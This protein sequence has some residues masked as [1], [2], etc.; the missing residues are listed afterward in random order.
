MRICKAL[1]V[2][3]PAL[4]T[5]TSTNASLSQ[6]CTDINTVPTQG[7][8]VKTFTDK[9]EHL[10]NIRNTLVEAANEFEEHL[11]EAV[12]LRLSCI[13]RELYDLTKLTAIK[14]TAKDSEGSTKTSSISEDL[15]TQLETQQQF[16][17][18]FMDITTNINLDAQS[19]KMKILKNQEMMV[20]KILEDNKE[21]LHFVCQEHME[22]MKNVSSLSDAI[23]Y[24]SELMLSLEKTLSDEVSWVEQ[25]YKELLEQYNYE[26]TLH[27]QSRSLTLEE[28]KNRLIVLLRGTATQTELDDLKSHQKCELMKLQEE[29]GAEVQR[30]ERQLAV[31]DQETLMALDDEVEQLRAQIDHD[32]NVR[33]CISNSLCSELENIKIQVTQLEDANDEL[34]KIIDPATDVNSVLFQR[35]L[36]S[37]YSD[38]DWY[39]K[40]V[41]L[42]SHVTLQLLHYYSVAESY[43]NKPQDHKVI[44]EIIEDQSAMHQPELF[45]GRVLDLSFLS[46][47]MP[48]D[49]YTSQLNMFAEDTAL[50]TGLISKTIYTDQGDEPELVS[51]SGSVLDSTAMS[52][53]M[54]DDVD[55]DEQVRSIL[56]KSYPQLMSILKGRWDRVVV[57]NL[58]KEVQEL[59]ISLQA[60]AGMLKIFLHS[61]SSENQ[62]LSSHTIREVTQ[63]DSVKETVS[64]LSQH[65]LS[66]TIEALSKTPGDEV[67]PNKSIRESESSCSTVSLKIHNVRKKFMKN[68]KDTEVDLPLKEDALDVTS[69][70]SQ[71]E[72]FKELTQLDLVNLSESLTIL[73][74]QDESFINFTKLKHQELIDEEKLKEVL[75][76]LCQNVQFTACLQMKLHHVEGLLKGLEEEKKT[77]ED[78]NCRLNHYSKNLA[79]ELQVVKDQIEELEAVQQDQEGGTACTQY[80]AKMEASKDIKERVR[81]TLSAKNK[82]LMDHTELVARVGD[83]EGI[84]ETLVRENDATVEALKSR[85]SDLSQQLEVAD[86]QLR[87][88]RQ[89]LEEHASERDQEM[90]DLMHTKDKL[91]SQLREK[92]ALLVQHANLEK[93]I[94]DLREI[95]Q[96]LEAQVDGKCVEESNLNTQVETLTAALS[97]AHQDSQDLTSKL[98]ALQCGGSIQGGGHSR[99]QLPT[100]GPRTV[101]PEEEENDA[102]LTGTSLFMELRDEYRQG[103]RNVSGQTLLQ[104]IEETVERTTSGLEALQLS[105]SS[106]SQ[107]AEDLSIQDHLDVPSLQER[108][109][110]RALSPASVDRRLEDKLLTLERTTEA[111]VKRTRDLE[112]TLKNLRVDHEEVTAERDVLQEH[113]KEQ[114]VQISSL[115]A[116]LD[117]IRRSEHPM[118]A[119]LRQRLNFVQENLEKKR[120]EITK[121][122][123]EIEELKHNLTSTRGKLMSRE[124]ELERMQCVSQPHSLPLSTADQLLTKQRHLEDELATKYIIIEKLKKELVDA[125]KSDTI[126]PLLAQSLIE[127]KNA[128][129]SE[130]YQQLRNMKSR[131]HEVVTF[132]ANGTSLAECKNMLQK[133][134]GDDKFSPR[135]SD[136]EAPEVLRKTLVQD[137]DLT[138]Y[139]S[140]TSHV[141]SSLK[142]GPCPFIISN[143]KSEDGVS[144]ITQPS[145]GNL[146][147]MSLQHEAPHEISKTSSSHT[148]M[149]FKI[150]PLHKDDRLETS[151]PSVGGAG[152][153][154]DEEIKE[155]VEE[156]KA[157]PHT[158]PFEEG[159]PFT[160]EEYESLCSASGEVTVLR[161]QI[162]LM[163]KEIDNLNKYQ[164]KL[165]EDYKVAQEMLEAREEE[166]TQLSEEIE[167]TGSLPLPSQTLHMQDMC[168]RLEEQV[169]ELQERFN[170]AAAMNREYEEEIEKLNLRTSQYEQEIKELQ[171]GIELLRKEDKQKEVLLLEKETSLQETRRE[172]DKN[173][174][175][176]KQKQMELCREMKVLHEQMEQLKQQHEEQSAALQRKTEE[177]AQLSAQLDLVHSEMKE[178]LSHTNKEMA[179]LEE[180]YQQEISDM[181]E[182]QILREKQLCSD[183]EERMAAQVS[184]LSVK[185][186]RDKEEAVARQQRFYKSALHE[187]NREKERVQMELQ[188]QRR[189]VDFHN[190]SQQ[191]SHLFDSVDALNAGVKLELDKSGQLDNSLV[192]FVKHGHTRGDPG[193]L[194]TRAS[195][196]VSDISDGDGPSDIAVKVQRLMN[197]V[198]K[199][200]IEMLTLIELMFLQKH[201]THLDNSQRTLISQSGFIATGSTESSIADIQERS[202]QSV[203]G[204]TEDGV[205]VG[206][207]T[208]LLRH[209][210]ALE[211]EL[212][213]KD[214]EI[215]RKV[216]LLEFRLEQEKKLGIE[217]KLSFESEKKR[218]RELIE[219]LRE[220]KL[221][222]ADR[223]S[224]LKILRSQFFVQRL[225]LQKIQGESS[226]VNETLETNEKEVEMLKDAL[227][228]ERNNFSRVSKALNQQRHL[229]AVTRSQQDGVIKDLRCTLDSERERIMDLY[230]QLA[231]LTN[232]Q[233][234]K[235]CDR[236]GIITRRMESERITSG[237]KETTTAITPTVEDLQMQLAV[238]KE[239]FTELQR[240]YERERRK[241]VTQNEQAH[242]ERAC[243]KVE[244]MEEQ[245]KCAE[246]TKTIRNM[247]MEKDTLLRQMSQNRERLQHQESRIREMEAEIRKLEGDLRAQADGHQA[248]SH[249]VREEDAQLHINYTR[250]LNKL[251]EAEA[252]LCTLR[253]KLRTVTKD[254]ELS[255]EKEEQLQQ[256]LTTEKMAINRLGLP[257]LARINNLDEYFELQL[258][259]NLELCK[260]V[261]RLT[262]DRQAMRQKIDTLENTVTDLTEQLIKTKAAAS[263]HV[264]FEK[265]LQ[266]ERSA[267]EKERTSLQ[268]IISRKDIEMTRLQIEAGSRNTLQ[269]VNNA[270]L[271]DER[272]QYMYGKYV[273]SEHWRKALIW[274]KRYL[275]VVIKG[276]R[277]DEQATLSRLR[278]MASQVHG[279]VRNEAVEAADNA[280]HP[281]HRFRVGALAMVAICRMKNM[282]IKHQRRKRL[283]S[284]ILLPYP[285]TALT[286]PSTPDA[287]ESSRPGSANQGVLGGGMS[288]VTLQTPPTKGPSNNI[289][290]RPSSSRRNLFLEE[291]SPRLNEYI[292]RLDNIH[293]ALGL[294]PKNI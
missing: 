50:S 5:D 123:R 15:T 287:S 219:Q 231:E 132:I 119:E 150:P 195:S 137:S 117:E 251:G 293:S 95:I 249:R 274:Q 101:E 97:L 276:Y 4:F 211:E 9:V 88:S 167:D 246:L 234:N 32:L 180:Q 286:I 271:D 11:E 33:S 191:T 111:A 223:V 78:E 43:T 105:V 210:A 7:D 264:D 70:S 85:V 63:D 17:H 214:Q 285:H 76:Q 90:E 245:G 118:T 200:G 289:W 47:S 3:L 217:W 250:S 98:E 204:K 62:D 34:H 136:A 25:Q 59:T 220:E 129:I 120:N 96:S 134:I 148:S 203:Q 86:R 1:R 188:E 256:E 178:R 174:D 183:Y 61:V 94:W 147:L 275:L 216:N 268:N 135:L 190:R 241:V 159:I 162:E 280:V 38:R 197:K 143:S 243:A 291:E 205:T 92:D 154:A 99:E 22:D 215:K 53:G 108:E 37:L 83:L 277:D 81:A 170:E 23:K 89:F 196:A 27:T 66:E 177:V 75:K 104:I 209:M 139:S 226:S 18:E 242:A 184:D 270:Q 79:M 106:A 141:I 157:A 213:K 52:E 122:G 192:S 253:H 225:E 258:K 158:S 257:A 56:T 58:E 160:K 279:A 114:L 54:L 206:E 21:K 266:M 282:V 71:S 254:L 149:T 84:L 244:L 68:L 20:H 252:E 229:A 247:E 124:E 173:V 294:N 228:A 181:K 166:I 44:N 168:F 283:G 28:L 189:A 201:Q 36:Q 100:Q 284:Q 238:E 45:S 144:F 51:N 272:V 145:S 91:A 273:R 237:V 73:L 179:Q 164:A 172:I 72:L 265:M 77:L 26:Q 130:L 126:P 80:A 262:D 115:E 186:G 185:L 46:D 240:S 74:S 193:D 194:S 239:R 218:A 288:Y 260:S 163:Q 146:T 187:A 29:H 198:D 155:M 30:L 171:E 156:E 65:H 248:A 31:R 133:I 39:K 14:L 281:K 6:D 267:W 67:Q 42:L 40:T 230:T 290:P 113:S 255:K 107:S 64:D 227:Q 19:E 161:A 199:E 13:K 102:Q 55:K 112:M 208:Q 57:E 16:I 212:S 131:V 10:I 221:A 182:E 48:D 35:H 140:L 138:S 69:Q 109:N 175:Q 12:T 82:S 222:S 169:V 261:L 278:N 127:D 116:R 8:D 41:G 60:S 207:R 2:S 263:N 128:E 24:S 93:E 49:S 152:T 259:E 233:A 153:S 103:T 236:R 110:N 235:Q 176:H 269:N 224:E 292:E 151:S 165:E 121:K 202:A 87:S 125:S 142:E 232:Q